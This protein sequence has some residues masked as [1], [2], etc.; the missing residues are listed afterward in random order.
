MAG[1]AGAAIPLKSQKESVAHAHRREYSKYGPSAAISAALHDSPHCPR[2]G[3]DGAQ[4]QSLYSTKQGIRP[5][6]ELFSWISRSWGRR[7]LSK[8]PMAT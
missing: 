4:D 8:P 7:Y 3:V 2:L 1:L 6:F 5:T